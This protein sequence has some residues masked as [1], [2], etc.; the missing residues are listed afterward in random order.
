M[1]N[2]G[3][4]DPWETAGNGGGGESADVY[5]AEV[6]IEGP[7]Y[8]VLASACD[9]VVRAYELSL[10]YVDDG[11]YGFESHIAPELGLGC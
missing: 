7:L 9:V 8:D 10:G 4:G 11:A 3:G 6:F 1:G 2:G 5:V